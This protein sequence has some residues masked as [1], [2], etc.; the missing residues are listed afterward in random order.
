MGCRN[1]LCQPPC[2]GCISPP[3]WIKSG[4]TNCFHIAANVVT[5]DD[6]QMIVQL[7]GLDLVEFSL[8]PCVC[9]LC[10]VAHA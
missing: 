6:M 3:P 4:C 2:V 1:L 10:E 7:G 8:S 9:S 5:C